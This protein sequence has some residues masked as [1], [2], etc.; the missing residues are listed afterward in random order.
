MITLPAGDPRNKIEYLAT[1][2]GKLGSMPINLLSNALFRFMQREP[3]SRTMVFPVFGSNGNNLIATQ[4]PMPA[5]M[6]TFDRWEFFVTSPSQSALVR[7]VAEDV[8]QIK[9]LVDE[10]DSVKVWQF[11]QNVP[12]EFTQVN[13]LMSLGIDLRNAAVGGAQYRLYVETFDST[14]KAYR[15]FER[16]EQAGADWNEARAT[17][18]VADPVD[19]TKPYKG[20]LRFGI[21]LLRETHGTHSTDEL[22]IRYP[23]LSIGDVEN[24]PAY[25]AVQDFSKIAAY[26]RSVRGARISGVIGA[27]G[28]IET[29]TIDSGLLEPLGITGSN[30]FRT[31]HP[32][33]IVEFKYIIGNDINLSISGN[34]VA[35]VGGGGSVKKT[36][37]TDITRIFVDANRNGIC[38]ELT[39]PSLASKAG[40]AVLIEMDYH[41]DTEFKF[42]G[43]TLEQ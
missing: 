11:C 7:Q 1:L 3:D 14:R 38:F 28:E 25:D 35:V 42:A 30:Y 27:G 12:V 16:D 33:V 43:Y 15:V 4:S 29:Q 32:N 17:F 31:T 36:D 5:S 8:A 24:S 34:E 41:I 6:T 22:D 2:I 9:M 20:M 40:Q 23:F 18:V 10:F 21:E 19:N 13:Q 39:A 26:T 37:G